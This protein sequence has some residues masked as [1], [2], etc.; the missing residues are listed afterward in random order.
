MVSYFGGLVRKAN[1]Q[2]LDPRFREEERWNCICRPL[3]NYELSRIASP[4]WIAGTSP[5]MTNSYNQ[6]VFTRFK[7]RMKNRAGW[8]ASATPA[9][10]GAGAPAISA[11]IIAAA[12]GA[13]TNPR[14]PSPVRM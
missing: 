12:S 9:S 7:S 1:T 10:T 3:V 5:A 2:P 13:E 4:C 6:P 14:E 8:S 11:A